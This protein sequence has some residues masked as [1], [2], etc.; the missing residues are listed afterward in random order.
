MRRLPRPPSIPAPVAHALFST[1]LGE[2]G[3]AWTAHGLAWIQLPERTP[4][5]TL[6]R[7]SAGVAARGAPSGEAEPPPWVAD[8]MERIA[9]HLAGGL[10]ELGIIPLDMTPVPPFFRR[11]YEEARAVPRGEVRTYAELAV[12]AG[13]PAAMRAVGQAMAKNPWPVVVP[14][15]RIVGSA[16]KPGGFS[17][18]G[19][20]DTKARLLALEGASFI[21]VSPRLKTRPVAP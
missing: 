18:P 6:A 3:L 19:G 16:G 4:A 10:A 12:A 2:C 13:S 9:A 7:L 14:C 5:A 17:A 8:A 20:L 15:H 1:S 21:V 11:V